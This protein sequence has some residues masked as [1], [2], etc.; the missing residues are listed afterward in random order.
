M[1]DRDLS[2]FD[3]ELNLKQASASIDKYC[4]LI[5]KNE[6]SAAKIFYEISSGAISNFYGQCDVVCAECIEAYENLSYVLRSNTWYNY[7]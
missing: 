7:F 6:T 3:V 4:T 1:S 2:H 5:E